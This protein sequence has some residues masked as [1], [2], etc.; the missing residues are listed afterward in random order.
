[1]EM[2]WWMLYK[3]TVFKT[4]CRQAPLGGVTKQIPRTFNAQ[5]PLAVVRQSCRCSIAL[6]STKN[7]E[8]LFT[9]T[10]K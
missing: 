1:M 7:Q 9:C 6:I 10:C 2:K 8:I 3:R 5:A 4:D